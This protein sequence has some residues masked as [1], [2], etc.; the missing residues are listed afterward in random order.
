MA[1]ASNAADLDIPD[2]RQLPLNLRRRTAREPQRLSFAEFR[3]DPSHDLA[4]ESN[5]DPETSLLAEEVRLACT[6]SMLQCLTRDERVAFVLSE[7]FDLYS[8]GAAWILEISPV[9][10]RKRL[11][12]TKHRIRGF[13]ESTCGL[14]NPDAFC[15]CARRV[16]QAIATGRIDPLQPTFTTHPVTPSGRDLAAASAQLENL[17]NV[18]AVMRAHPDYAAPDTKTSAI[19]ALLESGRFPLLE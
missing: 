16:P 11:E 17:H 19:T 1:W 10:Y 7:I 3:D 4:T 12:R 15:G 18:A 9:A 13:M 5:H 2:R 14:V 8:N 6:Q